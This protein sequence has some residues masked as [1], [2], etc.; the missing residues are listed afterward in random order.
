LDILGQ[1]VR[2]FASEYE[3][4]HPEKVHAYGGFGD[5]TSAYPQ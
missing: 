1:K 4:A 5:R 3:G 2:H